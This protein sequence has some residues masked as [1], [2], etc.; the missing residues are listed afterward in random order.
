MVNF[1]VLILSF[2]LSVLP[3]TAPQLIK[4]PT[5]L[6][7]PS[8][9]HTMGYNRATPFEL[10]LIFGKALSFQQP[11]G[12]ACCKLKAL[13]DPKTHKDD[14]ELTVYCTNSWANQIVYNKSIKEIKTYGAFGSKCGEFWWPQGIAATSDGNIYV[15]DVENHRVVHLKNKIVEKNLKWVTEIGKFGCDTSKFDHPCDVVVDSKGQIWIADCGNNRIQVFAQEGG[16]LKEIKRLNKPI[17]LAVIDKGERWSRYKDEFLVVIDDAGKRI[18]KFDLNG[19][20]LVRSDFGQDCEFSDCAI[21][22][23]GNIWVTDKLNNCLHKFDR[24]LR[25]I[26]KVLQP[27]GK[28]FISPR[29]ITIWKRFGQVF[30]VEREAI[31]YFWIGVDGYIEGCYPSI[32]NPKEKGVTIVLYLTELANISGKIYDEDNKEVRDFIPFSNADSRE[33]NIVWDGKDNKG[34]MV[35]SGEYRIEFIIEPTYSSK[36]YFEKKLEAKV[37]CKYE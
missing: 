6:V 32:F 12:I 7:R 14:D 37:I 2:A 5:T 35:K 18:Q 8:F 13:D 29:G 15:T 30:V 17:A 9:K 31:S 20:L 28:E 10:K 22:Y 11:Q 36:N 1:P 24:Y 3:L 16:F 19:K 25:Y 21:D 4:N 34:E 33:H 26:V 27:G 23:Y